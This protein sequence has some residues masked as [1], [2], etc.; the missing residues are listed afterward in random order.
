M[1]LRDTIIHVYQETQQEYLSI[2]NSTN[3]K[4]TLSIKEDKYI[5]CGI[6]AFADEEKNYA[7]V[8]YV[9]ID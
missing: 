2:G 7:F 5:D 1:N 3:L 4:T 6:T 8:K 9:L